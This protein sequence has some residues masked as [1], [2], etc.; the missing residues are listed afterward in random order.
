MKNLIEFINES[1]LS[2][3]VFCEQ[4]DIMF[5]NTNLSKDIM[6]IILNNLSKDF[7]IKICNYYSSK[8]NVEFIS[9]E[10]NQDLFI[11]YNENK[12]QII[13]QLSDFIIKYK[14]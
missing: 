5:K 14:I 8:N 1:Q 6:K 9:Y 13:N 3:K 7:I 10:P 12:E 11:N 4:F 2:D